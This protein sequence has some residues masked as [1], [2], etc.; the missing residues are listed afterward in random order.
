MRF[1]ELVV[2]AGQCER[3]GHVVHGNAS[4]LDCSAVDAQLPALLLVSDT[5]V[6]VVQLSPQRLLELVLD[7]LV[8][9]YVGN[10]EL[11]INLAGVQQEEEKFL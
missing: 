10:R 3:G 5:L 6:L 9:F 7:R 2:A 11:G 1:C 8:V 4:I